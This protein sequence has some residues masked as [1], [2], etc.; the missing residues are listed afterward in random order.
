MK[1]RR[2][3]I[4]LQIILGGAFLLQ[5]IILPVRPDYLDRF[6]FSGE[7]LKNISANALILL[8]FYFNYFY[9][10]PKLFL[11]KKYT[12]Y[13]IIV[14]VC[15]CSILFVS[16]TV[17]SQFF[18]SNQE[19]SNRSPFEA[20]PQ[21][22]PN[23]LVP[24]PP[25][26]SPPENPPQHH[27]VISKIRF[28]FTEND[29]TFFLFGSI[30]LFS[31]L[32]KISNQYYQ[33]KNAKQEAELN[34]LL[35]QVNPHFLF[36]ALN[37]IYTL[38]IKEKAPNSSSGLLKLSGLLRYMITETNQN[39]VPL[40][41]EILC[42]NDFIDLQKL[43]LTDNTQLDYTVSGNISE[44]QIA[45]MLLIPFVENAFKYG[46][47]PDENSKIQ[48]MIHVTD[49]ALKMDVSNN[50]VSV[51]R[52][53]IEKSGIGIMNAK[54]RLA[55]LYPDKHDLSISQTDKTFHVTLKILF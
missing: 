1:K 15:F 36:N 23:L 13:F 44:K 3:L 2:R 38:S 33:T 16:S 4:W 37:S 34:Y 40:E 7:V 22:P 43:R 5:P 46:V 49:D 17:M 51:N 20:Q 35:A 9:L 50:K 52:D 28:F 25:Q 32:L 54:K 55:L 18:H 6:V 48:I 10:I 30:V 14:L 11:S 41:K 31:L 29:Q 19:I 47:N 21:L 45:P 8:F 26:L 42:I 53:A 39:I 27:S 12:R 24:A